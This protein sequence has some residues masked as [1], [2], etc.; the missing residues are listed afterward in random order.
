M[1]RLS[2]LITVRKSLLLTVDPQSPIHLLMAGRL[3]RGKIIAVNAGRT[4]REKK[5]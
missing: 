3:G 5:S 2:L 1:L 4:R